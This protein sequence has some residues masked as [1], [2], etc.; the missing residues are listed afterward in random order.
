MAAAFLRVNGYRPE[1]EDVEAYE[2]LIG[3][4]ESG[5]MRFGELDRWLRLHA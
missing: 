2:F 3:L 5:Q 4:Y 1:F